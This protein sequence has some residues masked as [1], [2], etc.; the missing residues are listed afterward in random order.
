MMLDLSS[1]IDPG[2]SPACHIGAAIID[3]T[4]PVIP[5]KTVAGNVEA[6]P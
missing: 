3:Q 1:C 5:D 6:A 2:S 4:K